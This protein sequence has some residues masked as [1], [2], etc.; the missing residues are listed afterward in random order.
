MT[1]EDLKS[2][3]EFVSELNNGPFEDDREWFKS[4][5]RGKNDA[6][7]TG[8]AIALLIIASVICFILPFAIGGYLWYRK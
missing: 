2:N 6:R 1:E 4:Q 3:S 5:E 8:W 7:M